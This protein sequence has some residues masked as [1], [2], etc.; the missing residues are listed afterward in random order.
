MSNRAT[1]ENPTAVDPNAALH[2]QLMSLQQL[3]QLQQP[4]PAAVSTIPGPQVPVVAPGMQQP[5]L[6]QTAEVARSSISSPGF[7]NPSSG[8]IPLASIVPDRLYGARMQPHHPY[9]EPVVQKHSYQSGSPIGQ[10]G[11]GSSSWRDRSGLHLN[12]HPHVNHQTTNYNTS[13]DGHM[14]DGNNHVG[15][16]RYTEDMP[17]SNPGRAYRSDRPVQRDSPVYWDPN[18]HGERWQRDRRY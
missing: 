7:P 9:A 2:Q 5:S 13:Y 11:L 18:R 6:Q 10:P 8:S 14:R 1:T 4:Q 16:G 12:S 17:G 3:L 15:S